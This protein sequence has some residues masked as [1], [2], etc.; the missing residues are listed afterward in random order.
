[1]V[2][3]LKAKD[4]YEFEC[5]I[6]EDYKGRETDEWGCAFIFLGDIG[7]EY[8][9]CLDSGT[10]CSAIYK[11]EFEEYLSTNYD[12]YIH[13]EIDFDDEHWMENLEN[14]MCEA[15]IEFFEL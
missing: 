5:N 11:A 3:E 13:Y 8:N 14:A 4:G 1:M 7:A 12:E 6:G 2:K 15:L 10:N 9:Y